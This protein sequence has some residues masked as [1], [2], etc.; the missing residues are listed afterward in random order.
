MEQKTFTESVD[1]FLKSKNGVKKSWLYS[2]ILLILSIIGFSIP[3]IFIY[4]NFDEQLQIIFVRN[5][6]YIDAAT[7]LI[8]IGFAL[9]FAPVIWLFSSWMTGVNGVSSDK[10]FHIFMWAIYLFVFLIAICVAVLM[11]R[12]SIF[13]FFI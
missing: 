7:Y 9:L 8:F 2:F 10:N 12:A 3:L 4:G 11:I 1:S 6:S 13:P 5:A